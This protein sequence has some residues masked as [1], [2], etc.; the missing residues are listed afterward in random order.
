MELKFKKKL[1]I[2]YLI[3]LLIGST[4]PTQHGKREDII[5]TIIHVKLLN[6]Q[7][8]VRS[9]KKW[10][11]ARFL[12]TFNFQIICAVSMLR[13]DKFR[14]SYRENIEERVCIATLIQKVQLDLIGNHTNYKPHK[15]LNIKYPSWQRSEVSIP[16][17]SCLPNAEERVIVNVSILIQK[18]MH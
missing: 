5:T 18:S 8:F 12:R 2:F 16:Q 17:M 14:E 4:N 13:G 15:Q 3:S 1:L 7:V 11:R 6:L 10:R 9:I